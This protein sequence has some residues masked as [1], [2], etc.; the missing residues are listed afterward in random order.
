MEQ[1]TNLFLPNPCKFSIP[2]V[3][4]L[5]CREIH[6]LYEPGIQIMFPCQLI[7]TFVTAGTLCEE[8][9]PIIMTKGR[10]KAFNQLVII[11]STK[12]LTAQPLGEGQG[13]EGA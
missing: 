3:N 11:I 9:A 1:P 6:T 8:D 7:T 12:V 5:Q 2:I 4:D 13:E 10:K